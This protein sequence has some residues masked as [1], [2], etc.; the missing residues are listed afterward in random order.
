MSVD[1]AL[2]Y[3]ERIARNYSV[4][5]F[6][7]KNFRNY[8][9]AQCEVSATVI[10]ITGSNG[11]GKTNILEAISMLIPG[12]GLRKSSI[13][14]IENTESNAPWVVSASVEYGNAKYHIG[15]GRD[16]QNDKRIVK[17]NGEVLK[18]QSKLAE[19]C[20]ILYLTPEMDR[21]FTESRSERRGFMDQ[22]AT[23][24]DPEHARRMAIY[25]YALKARKKLLENSNADPD[26]I[27]VLERRMAEQGVAIAASRLEKLEWTKDAIDQGISNF[28]KAILSLEG[29]VEGWV[30][31]MP[32]IQAENLFKETL[33]NNRKLDR[34]TGRTHTGIHR[35]DF[36]VYHREKN[37]DISICST[38]EKKALLLA[39]ILANARAK[40]VCSLGIPILL[41]DEVVAHL[42]D[43]RR[44]SLADEILS[45]N[46]QCWMTGTDKTLFDPFQRSVQHLTVKNGNILEQ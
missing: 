20:S 3:E 14:E 16:Q 37:Q 15:T 19:Y 32:A 23:N 43:R 22:L 13:L 17:I 9:S 39:I 33:Q 10:V 21:I 35:T 31:K 42:D 28:P 44:S 27:T 36:I 6:T 4:S 30:E 46:A 7:L 29:E 2:K 1:Q 5:S 34:E 8:S 18:A 41:L 25:N 40:G 26:W 45:L 12:K 38:G 24:F 11:I